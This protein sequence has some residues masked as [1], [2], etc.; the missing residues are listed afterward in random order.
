VLRYNHNTCYLVIASSPHQLNQS[1]YTALRAVV[2]CRLRPANQTIIT[3][4]DGAGGM[5]RLDV[6]DVVRRQ[7]EMR[8]QSAPVGNQLEV[9]SNRYYRLTQRRTYAQRQT[10][11]IISIK[12]L[13]K[14][15]RPKSIGVTLRAIMNNKYHYETVRLL[16]IKRYAVK[17]CISKCKML[18]KY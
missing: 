15:R 12:I 8:A 17:N 13:Q 7:T 3:S 9:P 14:V 11:T 16:V 5:A 18:E 10:S 4:V 2:G 6:A 1:W